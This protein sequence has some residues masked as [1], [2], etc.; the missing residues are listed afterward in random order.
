MKELTSWALCFA[1]GGLGGSALIP[2][3]EPSRPQE[4]PLP[5]P[6]APAVSTPNLDCIGGMES[7][8]KVE[9]TPE[10][11]RT[12][13]EGQSLELRPT[14]S[15]HLGEP[16]RA[17]YAFRLMDDV[18]HVVEDTRYSPAVK[19]KEG[20]QGT[21]ER[22]VIPAGLPDGFYRGFLNLAA[23]GSRTQA[24]EQLQVFLEV[25]GGEVLLLEGDDW[26]MRSRSNQAVR[27]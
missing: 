3:T 21:A 12:G 10:A 9:L 13:P 6:T 18:G 4:K 2:S 17:M 25:R 26:H 20:E 5:S 8:L 11:Y 7:P 22:I 15:S 24:S 27:R 16:V 14:L 1:L 23:A 19:L